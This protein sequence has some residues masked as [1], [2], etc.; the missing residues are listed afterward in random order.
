MPLERVRE[1]IQRKLAERVHALGLR[2]QRR[3]RLRAL[4]YHLLLPARHRVQV[5]QVTAD[6]AGAC[7][8]DDA[9]VAVCGLR[10]EGWAEDAK[11]VEVCE[12][13]CLPF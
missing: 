13:V 4:R 12:V 6:I 1:D 10:A 2:V 8:E 5:F 7:C 3:R 11:E 9:H